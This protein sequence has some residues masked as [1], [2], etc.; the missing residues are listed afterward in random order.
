VEDLLTEHLAL[1]DGRTPIPSLRFSTE[2]IEAKKQFEVWREFMVPTSEVEPFAPRGDGFRASTQA[3][4][5]GAFHLASFDMDSATF[6]RTDH[7]ARVSGSDH[8]CLTIVNRGSLKIVSDDGHLAASTGDVILQTYGA[9]FS[10][11]MEGAALSCLFLSRDRF[12]DIADGLDRMIDQRVMGPMSTILRDFLVSIA[13][14]ADDLSTADVPAVNEAFSRLLEAAFHPT[15]DALHAA[16]SPVAATQFAM[17]RRI[18][19][20]HLKSPGLTQDAIC[21]KMGISR[22]QLYYVFERHG[23]VMKYITQRRLAACHDALVAQT[24]NKRISS[25]AYEYGFTHLSSFYRQFQARYGFRPGEARSAWLDGHA[26]RQMPGDTF[27]DWLAL[28]G[29][30]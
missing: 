24:G 14:H 15:A 27:A 11:Q 2:S 6:H 9:P 12:S 23:G 25:I 28:T 4:D 26:S 22:R 10:G 8:W 30:G 13:N 1:A 19:S 3:Y 17:A 16:R 5:L 29:G 7:H 18:I 20:Q 21:K